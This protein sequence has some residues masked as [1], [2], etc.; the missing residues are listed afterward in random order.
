MILK[1]Y[2]AL[3]NLMFLTVLIIAEEIISK[4]F[5]CAL[6]SFPAAN[7]DAF[8]LIILD[9]AIQSV[10]CAAG[11]SLCGIASTLADNAF[12]F[13]AATSFLSVAKA[14]FTS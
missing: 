14:F 10:C 2:V 12:T 3:L 4:D 11:K 8:A 9:C 6:M 1:T 13:W 5:L 7:S